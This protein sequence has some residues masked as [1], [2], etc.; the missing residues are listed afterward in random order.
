MEAAKA[1]L[2]AEA[3]SLIAAGNYDEAAAIL[4][5]LAKLSGGRNKS[6]ASASSLL[7]PPPLDVDAALSLDPQ[8]SPKAAPVPPSEDEDAASQAALDV[9]RLLEGD[10]L[11]AMN[12]DE[13]AETE[14]QLVEQ[15]AQIELAQ[16]R[17]KARQQE[18][19]KAK[20][21]VLRQQ[22][23]DLDK[24]VEDERRDR[25]EMHNSL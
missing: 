7:L 17:I 12:E 20:A 22:L 23:A 25:M 15:R 1:A 4:S 16:K 6:S 10:G 8:P 2:K 21:D 9:H 3:D 13:M 5:K 19:Q 18:Q 24:Q 11:A 14:Q